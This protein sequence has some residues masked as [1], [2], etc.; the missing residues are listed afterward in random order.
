MVRLSVPR[1]AVVSRLRDT[2]RAPWLYP[3]HVRHEPTLLL[4]STLSASA[5]GKAY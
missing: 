4:A 5:H 2:S 1:S 3:F